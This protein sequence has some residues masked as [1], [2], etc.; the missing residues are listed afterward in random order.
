MA[1]TIS[2]V[3]K[4]GDAKE[5]GAY[6]LVRGL[7]WHHSLQ[8]RELLNVT[9]RL[10]G[11]AILRGISREDMLLV[12]PILKRLKWTI[13]ASRVFDS[14][15]HT[16]GI[17]A[18]LRVIDLSKQTF[19]Q[20]REKEIAA[21][22]D[23]EVVVGSGNRP[24]Y[25]RDITVP[26]ILIEHKT[27]YPNTKDPSK[28]SLDLRDLDH[29]YINANSNGQIPVYI[30]EY[31]GRNGIAILPEEDIAGAEDYYVRD[32]YEVPDQA[33]VTMTM[34]QTLR[35]TDLACSKIIR[36]TRTW[37]II[38]FGELIDLIKPNPSGI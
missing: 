16:H 25:K 3:S 27:T 7:C 11:T 15:R 35:I 6:E 30:I 2:I 19:S 20:K 17:A 23:G 13:P 5:I 28:F 24:G 4:T 29:L 34:E 18:A 8:D 12:L 36:K 33:S 37:L 9:H 1:P 38:S 10:S 32:V 31:A 14:A 22:L 26:G 21:I